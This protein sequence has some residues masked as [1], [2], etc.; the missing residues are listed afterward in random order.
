[1]ITNR[2]TQEAGSLQTW[3]IVS[4]AMIVVSMLLAI[5]GVWAFMNYQEQ[6]NDVDSKIANAV[7]IAKKEQVDED[8][9]KFLEREK[10]PNRQF[11]GPSDYGGV[12]FDYPKT[13]SV[14]VYK[15]AASGGTYEAYL[16]PSVVWPIS[17]A[18]QFAA[19]VVI[20][21]RDY[22][23]VLATYDSLVK[24]GDLKS[25]SITVGGVSGA[26]L[27]GNFTK[28]IRGAAVLFKIRD[29]TLTVRTDA[30]TFMA[31]FDALVQTIKFN[32]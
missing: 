31:D 17:S 8:E 21:E 6:K 11:N 3:M 30:N 2:H 27:E 20:E 12:T 9:A 5:F 18:Q 13:W 28:D 32:Q 1:M 7:S 29:K 4:V 16:N 25:T 23:R 14:F 15:D 19:R 26:K 10:E 24:K 22:D